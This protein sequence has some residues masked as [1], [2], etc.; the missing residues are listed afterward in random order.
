MQRKR[1]IWLITLGFSLMLLAAGCKK[2]AVEPPPPPPPPPPV[3]KPAPPQPAVSLSAE[4]SSI[5]RGKSATLKWTSSNADSASLNQGIGTVQTSGSREVFPTQTT[6]YTIEVKGEG[7]TAS[8]SAEVTVRTP[9]PPP[10]PAAPSKTFSQS[11]NE[12]VRD[13]YFDYDK[14]NIR[15]DAEDALRSNAAA[16]KEVF[17]QFSDGRVTI[18]GHCDD[19]GT[20]E[21]NLALGDRRSTA[22]RDFLVNLG[23]P[24]SKVSTVSYGE[25]RPQCTEENEGCWQRNRR[26]H[27]AAVN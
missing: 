11:L 4:P 3:T 5:E 26:A 19:R 10:P 27:F 14:A 25:E 24:A 8:A 2:K 13:A 18:E 22:A 21:Y 17:G 23:V 7:G 1:R 20:N 16:L 12:R 6:R 9:P 15:P